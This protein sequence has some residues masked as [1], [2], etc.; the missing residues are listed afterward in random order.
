MPDWGFF[1][2]NP[3]Q[4]AAVLAVAVL[5]LL[6]ILVGILIGI[7]VGILVHT[8]I[9][10]IH[11]KDP[12]FVY[13]HG[14]AVLIGYPKDYDLSFALKMKLINKPNTIAAVIPPAEAF[15]PP[16]KIPINPS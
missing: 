3:G 12:P 9:L 4:L 15:N 6:V 5:V 14:N 8:L 7:L 11:C 16:R 10:I 2:N 13:I 1:E